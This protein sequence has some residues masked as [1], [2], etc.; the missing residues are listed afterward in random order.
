MRV[1]NRNG[2]VNF[3]S[4]PP[5]ALAVLI[6]VLLFTVAIG[7]FIVLY[8]GNSFGFDM[9]NFGAD[10]G[11]LNTA[12][13]RNR[14]RLIAGLN[15]IFT[16]LLPALMMSVLV[17]KKE[18]LSSLR[19]TK[20]PRI[21]V[22]GAGILFM[23]ASFAVAQVLY[24]WNSQLPLPDWM[25]SKE[26]SINELISAL[27]VADSPA[28]LFANVLLIGLLPALGEEFL[29]RGILQRELGRWTTS[30][31]LGVWLTAIIFSAIHLQF[32]GFMPRLV[33]GAALGYL[34]LWTD[35]LWVPVLAHFVNNG[36]QVVVQYVTKMDVTQLD[37]EQ[38]APIPWW[39]VAGS[40]ALMA[41]LG[42]HLMTNKRKQP[43][44]SHSP[45]RADST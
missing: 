8:L 13:D 18:A 22:I 35:N 28:E 7:S 6:L 33:L 4:S 26:N 31:A 39:L 3:S 15:Q 32:Q 19:L 21:G 30:G 12:T 27:L 11:P 20:L 10:T 40:L 42:M 16:F 36:L 17:Y 45:D 5:M 41:G 29:F 38:S 24:R 23:L 37:A 44:H 1:E 9:A 34:F 43:L 25:I 14:L 2:R